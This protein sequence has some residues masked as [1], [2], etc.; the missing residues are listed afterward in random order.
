LRLPFSGRA[1]AVDDDVWNRRRTFAATRPRSA[2]VRSV[3]VQTAGIGATAALVW[4]LRDA[5]V[6]DSLAY[7]AA[8]AFVDGVDLHGGPAVTYAAPAPRSS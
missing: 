8:P 6:A 7:G 5:G 3:A 2:R 1:A 4:L